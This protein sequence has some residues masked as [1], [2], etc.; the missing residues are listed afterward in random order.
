[1]EPSRQTWSSYGPPYPLGRWSSMRIGK[2]RSRTRD[3]R[4]DD[5]LIR[6]SYVR[7]LYRLEDPVGRIDRPLYPQEGYTSDEKL[8]KHVLKPLETLYALPQLYERVESARG[9]HARSEALHARANSAITVC[10]HLNWVY[11]HT[12]GFYVLADSARVLHAFSAVLY[13]LAKFATGL[14]LSRLI[15]VFRRVVCALYINEDIAYAI[16]TVE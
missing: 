13:A 11:E 10:A 14:N 8:C 16:V 7:L 6:K 3:P 9:L 12:E 4:K 5:M 2:R 1:M 15:F